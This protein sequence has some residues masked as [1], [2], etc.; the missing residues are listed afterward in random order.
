[1]MRTNTTPLLLSVLLLALVLGSCG[2]S[3]IAYRLPLPPGQ[4]AART[5]S[6]DPTA[7]ALQETERFQTARRALLDWY[8]AMAREDVQAAWERLS[9]ETRLLLDDWSGGQGDVALRTGVLER[10][11]QRW[12]FDP[13]DLL[14]ARQPERIVDD[15]PGQSQQ[16]TARRKELFLQLAGG[17]VRRVVM[18]LEADQWR[19]HSPRIPTDRL[20]LLQGPGG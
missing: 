3:R 10:Q 14:A 7:Q 8:D 1:M 15:V 5:V 4:D 11:G 17:E 6:L 20:T 12:S 13:L 19:I 9:F 18:I 16:E 2:G